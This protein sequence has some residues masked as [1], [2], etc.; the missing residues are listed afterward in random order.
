MKKIVCC[1]AWLMLS[2]QALALSSATEYQSLDSIKQHISAFLLTQSNGYPGKV[3]VDVG[4]IDPRL[5]LET[6]ADVNVFMPSGSRPWGKTSVG[7]RCTVPKAWT[8]Y[9][10]ANVSVF[11]DYLVAAAPLA[12]GHIL[13]AHHVLFE[14][15]DLTRLPAG[16]LTEHSQV[17]GRVVSI[18]MAAGT[19]LRQEMLKSMPVV[20]QGQQVKLVSSGEGFT[21][22]AEGHALDKAN[23]GQVVKVKVA[24]GQIIS[25]IAKPGGR[26]EV[27]Y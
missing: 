12:Q 18:S 16:I 10:Q 3:T 11:S 7:V 9:V 5:K 26:V 1:I 19:V 24:S 13:E 14:L 17:V 25:G 20:Q 15:G 21:V 8:I 4:R 6:C 23:E 2:K 22:T 27:V